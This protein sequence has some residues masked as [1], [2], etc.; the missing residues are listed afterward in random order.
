MRSNQNQ[1]EAWNGGESVHYVDH[2]DRYDR[3]LVPFSDALL[4][5]G[6]LE[7]H[8]ALLD[9]GC[10]CGATTLRAAGLVQRAVGADL[11]EPLVE[12]ASRG[13]DFWDRQRRV[14]HGRRPDPPLRRRH[15]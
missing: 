10:G 8:H 14:R 13:S 12:I 1:F 3:Q 5:R 11:S 4:A 6:G 7:S 15:L 9:I 2:S